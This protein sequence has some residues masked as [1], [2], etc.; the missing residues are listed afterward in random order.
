V[1]LG[2][3]YDRA[4]HTS[5]EIFSPRFNMSWQPRAGT[6]L[7]GAWGK[8]SQAQPLAALQAQD[9][10]DRFFAAERAEHRVMGV[11]QLLG[12]GMM[13][14]IEAYDRRL[15]HQRP[16]FVSTAPGIEMFPEILP[17]RVRIDPERG[18]ARG[19]ELLLS[20]DQGRRADWSIGYARASVTDHIGGR[21]V[22]RS[23]DQ[24]HT[25]T[26]DWSYRPVSNKWRLSIA[27]VW[28]SGWP[29]TPQVVTL[30]TI[31]NTQN[32]LDVLPHWT[33][34]ALNSERLPS[35]RRVDAR[36]TRYIDTR[37]GRVSLFIEAYNLFGVRN[38]RGYYTNLSID[39]QRRVSY[40]LSHEDG[41][42]RL[43]TFGI[44][45][46]FGGTGR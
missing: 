13:V 46:E 10:V 9:G 1:E 24:R 2:L 39:R 15:S 42:P 45:W 32:T 17:D 31:A 29:Y 3:R 11:E 36:W 25:I 41:I 22:P 19:I 14:R 21:D 38:R 30:D 37:T 28:H 26:A 44:T 4:S 34:G 20:R 27:G 18:R 23:T 33:P 8:Y 12:R 35:Y 5:D 16:L 6:S 7:R 43:P 40:S